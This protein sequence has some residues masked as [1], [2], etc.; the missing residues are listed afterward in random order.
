LPWK[1]KAKRQAWD[2]KRAQL[3]RRR[4]ALQVGSRKYDRYYSLRRTWKRTLK[5]LSLNTTMKEDNIQYWRFKHGYYS[6]YPLQIVLS[7]LPFLI[8]RILFTRRLEFKRR[9]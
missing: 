4:Y 1:D 2:S 5:K 6:R 3:P 9:K 7:A 8:R